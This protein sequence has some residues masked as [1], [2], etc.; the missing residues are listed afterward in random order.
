MHCRR[1]G[2]LDID[3]TGRKFTKRLNARVK[4]GGGHLGFSRSLPGYL[5]CCSNYN[6]CFPGVQGWSSVRSA[7]IPPHVNVWN[8]DVDAEKI[9]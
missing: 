1:S 3:K 2:Q 9:Q 7:H 6:M 8:D 4:V 5:F